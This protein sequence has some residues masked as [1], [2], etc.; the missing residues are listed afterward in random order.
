MILG[1]EERTE[2]WDQMDFIPPEV[3][4]IN[5][6]PSE[7]NQMDFIPPEVNQINFMPSEMNQ[8]NPQYSRAAAGSQMSQFTNNQ[9]GIPAENISMN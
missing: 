1:T 4:Q 3:N 7:M 2:N 9:S 5:F 6:I 8:V